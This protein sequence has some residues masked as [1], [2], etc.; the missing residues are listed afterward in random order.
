MA[1]TSWILLVLIAVVLC[2]L[3]WRIDRNVAD[4]DR[5]DKPTDPG[6]PELVAT[7]LAAAERLRREAA[8]TLDPDEKASLTRLADEATA[9]A[10]RLRE[11]FE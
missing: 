8:A 6:E 9:D 7:Q 2:A 1:G 5:V 10:T 11:E 4:A 3:F